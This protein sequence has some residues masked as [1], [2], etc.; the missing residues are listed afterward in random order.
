M[1]STLASMGP[2]VSHASSTVS[3]TGSPSTSSPPL[4]GV[5][6]P[7][8]WVP[9]SFISLVRARPSRPVIPWTITRLV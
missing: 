5:T 9:Y 1:N 7:M 8:I 6:P 4:P 2:K 3:H